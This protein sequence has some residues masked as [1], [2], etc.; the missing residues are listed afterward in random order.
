MSVK[1]F[2]KIISPSGEDALRMRIRTEKGK[3][4]D[5]VVQYEAKFGEDWHPIVRYDCSHGFFHRDIMFPGGKEEKYPL[6][7]PDLKTALVYA[8]Q[9]IKDRWNWYR[10][11]YQRRL[12]K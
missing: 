2:V 9:D 7:I 3:V 10:D 11:R 12:K 5:I 4:M 8:E 1:E 6:N